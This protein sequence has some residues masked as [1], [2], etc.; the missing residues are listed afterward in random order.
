[1][2]RIAADGYRCF[3]ELGPHPL[4]VTALHTVAEDSGH[5]N[6]V[7]VGSLRRDEDGP[8]CLDR[9]TAELHVHGRRIDWRRLVPDTA[10]ADLPTYAWDPR[11]H[12]IEPES[13][14]GASSLFDRAAHPLLGI[15]LHRRTRPAG[16]SGASGRRTPP[17]GCPDHTVFGRTVVSGTTLIELCRAALAV[18]RPDDP[19][20]LTDLL[21]LS[22]LTLPD[23]GTVEVSVEVVTAGPLPEITVH[24][25]PRAQEATGW[26][27]HATAFRVRAR[28]RRRIGPRC[29]RRPPNR[30]GPRERTSGSPRS[31]SA[32]ARPSRAYGRRSRPATAELAQARLSLPPTARDAADPYPLHPALL[33]AALH[34]AAGL[35]ASDGRVLLPVAVGRCVLPP[36]GA[37]DLTAARRPRAAPARTSPWTR[38]ALWDTDGFPAGRLEGV[39]LRAADPADLNG[40]SENARHL[41]EVVWTAVPEQPDAAAGTD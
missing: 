7:A 17:T 26:T 5:E 22:P 31:A 23:S 27:L 34:V 15:Q 39:R 12:W 32:T 1:M 37:R 20:D 40:A 18:A 4:L 16:P 24:S 28:R 21:L 19:A 36:G 8:A 38:C 10:P 41:Y 35:D 30:P 6:L 33:D 2:E 9:A 11:R 13:T 25:R 29:G 14:T 3:V